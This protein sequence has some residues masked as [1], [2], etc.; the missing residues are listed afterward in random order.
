MLGV[1]VSGRLSGGH[2]NSAV[3][4]ALAAF[5]GFPWRKVVP[6]VIA[7]TAGGKHSAGLM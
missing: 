1:Y 6:Y 3:T 5:Q 2:N 4:I 7:Q